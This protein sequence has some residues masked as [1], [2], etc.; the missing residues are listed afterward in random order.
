MNKLLLYIYEF[1]KK[2]IL[3]LLIND[4]PKH[5]PVNRTLKKCVEFKIYFLIFFELYK[6][7]VYNKSPGFETG[8]SKDGGEKKDSG[9]F[10]VLLRYYKN[11]RFFN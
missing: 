10:R 8:K 4:C 11:I 5:R 3:K 1:Y 9:S 2:K 7:L 6:T